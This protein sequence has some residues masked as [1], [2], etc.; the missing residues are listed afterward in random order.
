MICF[1]WPQRRLITSIPDIEIPR[2]ARAGLHE[3]R[4]KA[5]NNKGL[6][7]KATRR[8]RKRGRGG[9]GA[10]HALAFLPFLLSPSHTRSLPFCL[11]H[12]R[13]IDHAHCGAREAL[14]PGCTSASVSKVH[15]VTPCGGW[16]DPSTCI[17][18]IKKHAF[19]LGNS[20]QFLIMF[21]H[22]CCFHCGLAEHSDRQW[23]VVDFRSV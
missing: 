2:D 23:G 6:R 12:H 18:S 10:P 17:F 14:P 9:R 13:L 11:L 4:A 21:D 20:S 7:G 22:R 3:A 1:S 8:G 15:L 16:I 5:G 19:C